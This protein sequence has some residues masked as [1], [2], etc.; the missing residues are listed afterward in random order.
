MVNITRFKFSIYFKNLFVLPER[1]CDITYCWYLHKPGG[2]W[3]CAPLAIRS[4]VSLCLDPYATHV[5]DGWVG[6]L[7]NLNLTIRTQLVVQYNIALTSG[8]LGSGGTLHAERPAY[9]TRLHLI[10]SYAYL[11]VERARARCDISQT[12]CLHSNDYMLVYRQQP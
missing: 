11:F 3:G 10:S 12:L 9:S 2:G 8:Q 1:R 5:L 4:L 7:L 6:L